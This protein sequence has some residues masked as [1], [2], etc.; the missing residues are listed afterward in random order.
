MIQV[1]RDLEKLPQY[2][3]A[4]ITI[5][6]F[7]GVHLGHQQII[8]LLK[9][10]AAKTGGET[11]IITFHPHPRK[12]VKSGKSEVKII[13]TLSEKIELLDQLGIDHL[14]VVS[15][16]EVFANQTAEEYIENFLVKKFHPKTIIIGYDHKFGRNRSGDYHLLEKMGEVFNYSVREIPERVL[17]EIIISSTKVREALLKSDLD[18]ANQFLGYRYFFEGKVVIGNKLGRTIGYPTANLQ[19]E[20]EEKLVPGNGVYAVELTIGSDKAIYKGMMNI[21]VRPTVDGTKRTI[22]VNIFDFDQDIY[23]AN[24]R[25]F[26]NSYLRGEVKF[27]GLDQLK[28]Q[29][30]KDKVEAQ[31]KL[32]D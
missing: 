2:K 14:V 30:A 15:F 23:G 3:N 11:V 10:E 7:D 31:E 18:T 22:E 26:V 6:T 32:K 17:N 13:N 29:L 16:N 27:S 4:V 21:G 25:V 5:G 9:E 19:I 28:E 24:M 12:I 1:H 20:D 8:K